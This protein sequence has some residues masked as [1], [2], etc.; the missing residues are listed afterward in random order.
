MRR[1]P[2]A[3]SAS[4]IAA[5]AVMTGTPATVDSSSIKA[6]SPSGINRYDGPVKPMTIA[7]NASS[8]NART[9]SR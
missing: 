6:R 9:E 1:P 3:A 8:P 5:L 2:S 4:P 7:D